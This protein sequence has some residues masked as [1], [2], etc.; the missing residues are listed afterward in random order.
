MA[1][2]IF[3]TAILYAGYDLMD[4]KRH[5]YYQEMSYISP[6]NPPRGRMLVILLDGL[7]KDFAFSDHMPFISSCRERGAWGISEV[8]SIP[9]SIAG[10]H[11]IFAGKV[12]NPLSIFENFQ[13][14]T[15]SYDNLFE[16]VTHQGKRAVILSSHCLRGAYGKYTDL[17][18]FQPKHFLFSEYRE[19]ASY[20]FN[21][22]YL[23]LKKEKWDLAVVQ[24]ITLDY[25]GHL[26]TPLSPNYPAALLL[27]DDYV[28]QLVALTTDQDVVLITSEHGMDNRGFHMDRSM[29][30]MDTPFII[31][32]PRIKD[33]GPLKILQIDWAPTLS[34]LAGVS[35]FY[36]SPA[37]PALDL[38]KLSAEDNSILLKEFSQIRTGTSTPLVLNELREKR[39]SNMGIKGSP[40]IG[41]FMVLTTLVCMTLFAYVALAA[42]DL[43]WNPR[44]MFMVIGGAVLG[45]SLLISIES[46]FGILDHFSRNIPFSANFIFA[47]PFR[48]I[49]AFLLTVFLAMISS[50][51]FRKKSYN[52]RE[53]VMLFTFALVF[54]VIFQHANPYHLLN[55]VVL[56]IPLVAFGLT[57]RPAWMVVFGAIWIGIAIRRLTFYDVYTPIR[58]PERWILA[59]AVFATGLAFL[60]CRQRN[61]HN[62]IRTLGIGILCFIPSILAIAWPSSVGVHTILLL[63]CF[64][65]VELASQKESRAQDVWLALWVVFFFLGTSSSINHTTHIV[66]LPLL[67]AVWSTARK[68]SVVMRGVMVS[69]VIWTFYLMPGNS[70]DLKLLE[71]NDRFILNSAMTANIKSTVLVIASRYI[72]PVAVL[73]WGMKMTGSRISMFSIASTALLPVVC[74]IGTVFI[75]MISTPAVG[76]P[77]E[78]LVRLTVLLGYL[79]VLI[80]AFL[81]VAIALEVGRLFN[82]VGRHQG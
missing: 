33:G 14:S 29:I 6:L 67:L 10:D 20:V 59:L 35:P 62:I 15:S 70:F 23:F 79:V 58:L 13:G 40:L 44:V 68:A 50:L 76:F 43:E 22:A 75:M 21:Q 38:I 71:L 45:I 82:L 46:H 4:V 5:A 57:R 72:F 66:A 16:R 36:D 52:M 73:I 81:I 48:V 61:D 60:Y 28:R 17:A 12:A 55:W 54:G 32:G 56:G 69:L 7:R 42:V 25:I 78:H 49:F 26:E 37:L 9:L 19:D 31:W 27:I 34:I 80:S 18:A 30:V 77:W 24:F 3:A 1:L 74:G 51:I 41:V 8:A 2:L 63:L 65:P 39:L 11:A 64:I 47:H 53:V